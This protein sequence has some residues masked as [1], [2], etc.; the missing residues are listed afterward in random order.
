MWIH[1]NGLQSIYVT[2]V[3]L[4]NYFGGEPVKKTGE[5]VRVKNSRMER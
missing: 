4:D 3:V 2:L 5:K 1:K